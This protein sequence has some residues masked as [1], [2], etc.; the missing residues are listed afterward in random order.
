[1]L[2]GCSPKKQNK[3]IK[4]RIN[5][6]YDLVDLFLIIYPKETHAHLPQVT[7]KILKAALLVM[8]FTPDTTQVLSDSRGGI[9]T[10]VYSSNRLPHSNKKESTTAHPVLGPILPPPLPPNF[11]FPPTKFMC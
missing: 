6:P 5:L 2:H 9:F 10:V 1:M 8:T 4:L 7:G 3:Q 11:I